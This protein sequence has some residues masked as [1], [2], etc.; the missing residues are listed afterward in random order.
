M[1]LGTRKRE[2]GNRQLTEQVIGA[3]MR[4]PR[5]LDPGFLGSI[6]EESFAAGLRLLDLSFE[7][8]K[9]EHRFDLLID[10]KIAV[11]LEAIGALEN[12]DYAVVRSYLKAPGLRDA[13]LLNF[14]AAPWLVK[15]VG[16]EYQPHNR[17]QVSH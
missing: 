15:R 6:D 13:L 11:E 10:S 12:I 17:E 1:N 3:A 9:R 2:S 14:A 8:Q 4:I 5:E 16:H 7:R